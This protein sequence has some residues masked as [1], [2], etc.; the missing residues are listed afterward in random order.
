MYT[1][2]I[3]HGVLGQGITWLEITTWI[4]SDQFS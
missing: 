3:A 4:V 2:A 1:A